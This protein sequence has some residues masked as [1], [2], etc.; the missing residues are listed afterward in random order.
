MFNNNTK[1]CL[2]N[3]YFKKSFEIFELT[4][5]STA[6]IMRWPTTLFNIGSLSTLCL[7]GIRIFCDILSVNNVNQMVF[8]MEA[9]FMYLLGSNKLNCIR[10]MFQKIKVIHK[11]IHNRKI[12]TDDTSRTLILSLIYFY[13]SVSAYKPIIWLAW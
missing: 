7:L 3:V 6:D 9:K 13:Q 11:L 8:V 5:Y 4:L 10:S 1:E 2:Y 12:D